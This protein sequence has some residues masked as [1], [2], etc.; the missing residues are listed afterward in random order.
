[1]SFTDAGHVLSGANS[2]PFFETEFATGPFA[3]GR[4]ATA[5]DL[6]VGGSNSILLVAGL[7]V[8]GFFVWKAL[9]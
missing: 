2:D 3:V 5:T 9:K 4:N 8:V 7:A 6:P 1:L